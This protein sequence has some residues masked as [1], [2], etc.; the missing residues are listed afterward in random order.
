MINDLNTLPKG[1]NSLI[2]D[3]LAEHLGVEPT[4]LSQEDSFSE[5]LN[6]GLP[7]FSDFI[8]KLKEKGYDTSDVEITTAQTIGEL[9]G[10]LS[11][12]EL[13]KE[14]SKPVVK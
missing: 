5:Q 2:I 1:F 3:L 12:N 4:D 11:P 7:D 10:S 9:I 14:S 6:M 8:E 13:I